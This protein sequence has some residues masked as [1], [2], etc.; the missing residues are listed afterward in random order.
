MIVNKEY[1]VVDTKVITLHGWRKPVLVIF[2]DSGDVLMT[3][4]HKG[5]VIPKRGVNM[6]RVSKRNSYGYQTVILGEDNV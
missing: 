5:K 6:L 2:T 1:N 4:F 3:E